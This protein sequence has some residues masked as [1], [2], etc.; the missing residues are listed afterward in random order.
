M[1]LFTTFVASSFFYGCEVWPPGCSFR[2]RV[3]RAYVRILKYCFRKDTVHAAFFHGKIPHSTI[4][5]SL[6]HQGA[7]SFLLV[8]EP[9]RC[10]K[11]L[12]SYI[13]RTIGGERECWTDLAQNRDDWRRFA[14]FVASSAENWAWN[15]DNN[16]KLR[17]WTDIGRLDR[18]IGLLLLECLAQLP[19]FTRGDLHAQT[20]LQPLQLPPRINVFC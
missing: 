4:G 16:A 15:D 10:G 11:L 14:K 19:L 20:Q 13:A 18:R 1:L 6:R 3:D 17:R 9:A 7:L 8:T 5:H 12:D 2:K